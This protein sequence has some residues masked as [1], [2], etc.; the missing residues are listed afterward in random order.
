VPAVARGGKQTIQLRRRQETLPAAVY[1][2][3]AAFALPSVR[4]P[5]F[6]RLCAGLRALRCAMGAHSSPNVLLAQSTLYITGTGA[7]LRSA[8]ESSKRTGWGLVLFTPEND[9]TELFVAVGS[10]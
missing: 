7:R 2:R 9:M 4:L 6:V 5:V 10:G 8:E 1:D 3:Y